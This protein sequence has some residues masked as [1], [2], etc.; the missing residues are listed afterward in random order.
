MIFGSIA[1][2]DAGGAILAH[3]AGPFRKGRV[4][5]AADIEVLRELGLSAVTAARLESDDVA[6]NEAAGR[7]ARACAGPNVRIGAAFT[8]RA[9]LYAETHGVAIVDAAKIDALNR[10]H[11]AITLATLPPFA[12]LAERQMLATVKIIPFSVTRPAVE[13]AEEMLRTP[14]VSVA[15]F[16][17][18]RVAL[19]STVLPGTKPALLDKNRSAIEAR[20]NDIGSALALELRVDHA[21]APLAQAI[22]EA[23]GMDAIL[24]FGA[25]AITDR[26]D[27]IPAAIE[28][29]G[30]ELLAFGMPVDPGNLLLSAKL[31]NA[32]VIGLPGCA[33]S[34]KL[35]G[36][37]FVLRRLAAGLPLGRSELAAMGVGGLLTEIP[38]RPQPR[39]E[40]PPQLPKVAAVVLAAGLSSRMGSHKL[41][42]EVAGKPLVRYAVEAALDSAPRPVL[43]VT[44]HNPLNVREALSG[45]DISFV[46][47]PD[48][49]KGLSTSLK[50]GLRALPEGVDAAIILLGD[51]PAV[52]AGLIDALIAAFDPAEG[53]A[54]CLPVS[55]G[56]RGN[57]VL[58]AR[59]F[60]PDMLKLEGD[61]GAKALLAAYDELV[62]E[63][64]TAD[65]GSLI[66]I[67]TQQALEAYR[68]R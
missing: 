51:M 10:L 16:R 59:R 38:S 19:I 31:G 20:L 64:E 6:E 50:Y 39:D 36:F 15:P 54:I 61:V 56:R 4:L 67:D 27:V 62:C 2:D 43:V 57:P 30:G 53:R 46:D 68:S 40:H 17:P 23:R 13:A 60:F 21:V 29:A 28:A 11:E 24:V 25:S 1:I 14:P 65:D 5:S 32:P 9:N 26:R 52:T 34:P 33:R 37:D 55:G 44:G 58:W 41:L 49:S 45:L 42:E 12:S 48:Y 7:I 63:V 22:G 35:N 18:K 8:G 3:R 47:N 66:D